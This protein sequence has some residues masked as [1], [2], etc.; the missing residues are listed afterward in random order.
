MNI[1]EFHKEWPTVT[2]CKLQEII[3]TNINPDSSGQPKHAIDGGVERTASSSRFFKRMMEAYIYQKYNIDEGV[4]IERTRK[5]ATMVEASLKKMGATPEELKAIVPR[6]SSLTTDKQ[7]DKKQGKK[8]SEEADKAGEEEAK[9]QLMPQTL[10]LGENEFEAIASR[11]LA[12]R[13]ANPEK[14]DSIPLRSH[15]TMD[16]LRSAATFAPLFDRTALAE[17]LENFPSAIQVARPFSTH[18]HVLQMDVEA[19]RDDLNAPWDDDGG[20]VEVNYFTSATLFFTVVFDLQRLWEN[21]AKDTD[22]MLWMLV[23]GFE[24]FLFAPLMGMQNT[25]LS[26]EFPAFVLAEVWERGVPYTYPG[27]FPPP[28]VLSREKSIMD[29]SVEALANQM[30]KL[31]KAYS[32]TRHVKLP[33]RAII[34]PTDVANTIFPAFCQSSIMQNI[35]QMVLWLKDTALACRK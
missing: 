10:P 19:V 11:L 1:P 26:H 15:F 6:V 8:S 21:V 22:K 16:K 14:F 27:A 25:A 9:E 28:I 2:V 23:E 20:Y 12:A 35:S 3:L 7:A 13:R 34:N 5:L 31:D 30:R 4:Q 33:S 17:S 18:P 32:K 24:A 29:G